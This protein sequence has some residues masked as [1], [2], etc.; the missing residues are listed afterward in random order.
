MILGPNRPCTLSGLIGLPCTRRQGLTSTLSLLVSGSCMALADGHWPSEVSPAAFPRPLR[1]FVLSSCQCCPPTHIATW[2]AVRE[3][4]RARL[5]DRHAAAVKCYRILSSRPRRILATALASQLPS[6]SFARPL[7]SHLDLT[8]RRS[9]TSRDAGRRCSPILDP[10]PQFFRCI[11]IRR[12]EC[13][14]VV[15]MW[16][17]QSGWR[18]RGHGYCPLLYSYGPTAFLTQRAHTNCSRLSLFFN[19]FVIP[20]ASG[21]ILISQR[22]CNNFQC[23]F[24]PSHPQP[25]AGLGS[26]HE[27]HTPGGR[28]RAHTT[29]GGTDYGLE[30]RSPKPLGVLIVHIWLCATALTCTLDIRAED[31]N[32]SIWLPLSPY[33]TRRQARRLA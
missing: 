2:P 6:L 13:C 10:A 3:K 9:C 22:Y 15:F 18:H 25:R 5:L 32:D 17:R 20:I 26:D 11:V 24:S 16:P 33:R 31:I 7:A 1:P 8:A 28:T 12:G 27:Y 30:T 14:L 23:T 21:L 4:R 19:S 29:H